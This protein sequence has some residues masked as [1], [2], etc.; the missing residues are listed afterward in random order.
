MRRNKFTDVNIVK[1]NIQISKLW[2]EGLSVYEKCSRFPAFFIKSMRMV[3]RG[4]WNS[5]YKNKIKKAL[6]ITFIIVLVKTYN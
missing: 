6:I 2:L 5:F 1:R 4:I 3:L